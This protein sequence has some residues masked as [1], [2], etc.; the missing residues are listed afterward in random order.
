MQFSAIDKVYDKV[1][2]EVPFWL[3][4]GCHTVP[5][6]RE[7]VRTSGK[8]DFFSKPPVNPAEMSQVRDQSHAHAGWHFTISLP[9]LYQARRF[10]MV[11]G[12]RLCQR[13]DRE[14]VMRRN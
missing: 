2:V 14:A 7:P 12:K 5:L 4:R 1:F 8:W 10:A 9:E 3:Q 6:T 11:P 13:F